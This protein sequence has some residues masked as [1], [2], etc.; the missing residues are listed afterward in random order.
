VNK[1]SGFVNTS[2]KSR[3]FAC[4]LAA[5]FRYRL[6]EDLNRV[7]ILRPFLGD[8]TSTDPAVDPHPTLAVDP[9]EAPTDR[10]ENFVIGEAIPLPR[11]TIR[12]TFDA[13]VQAVL[14]PL[15]R[16]IVRFADREACL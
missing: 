11:N 5:G 10:L 14:S 1:A 4:A 8:L 13:A 16:A 3:F 6:I 7:G 9:P 12:M 2:F 15:L